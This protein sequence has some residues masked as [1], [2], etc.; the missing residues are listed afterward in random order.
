MEHDREPVLIEGF[1]AVAEKKKPRTVGVRDSIIFGCGI[2]LSIWEMQHAIHEIS[3][4]FSDFVVLAHLNDHDLVIRIA[5]PADDTFDTSLER[6]RA[7]ETRNDK[8]DFFCFPQ[9]ASDI[10]RVGSP[11]DG[12]V[13]V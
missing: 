5:S 2:I 1:P 6:L 8:G 4:S 9:L 3:G 7:A 11:V 13:G 12:N 10:K